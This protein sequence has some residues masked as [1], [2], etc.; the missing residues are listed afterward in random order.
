MELAA[1]REAQ[2]TILN[3]SPTTDS[4]KILDFATKRNCFTMEI[5][6]EFDVQRRDG[7][8]NSEGSTELQ[9]VGKAGLIIAQGKISG[10]L[11]TDLICKLF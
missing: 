8:F 4:T 7:T 1:T 5:L 9:N 3:C 2:D 10:I 6:E 11:G